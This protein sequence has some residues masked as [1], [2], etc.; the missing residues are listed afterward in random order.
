[1]LC[2]VL[3]DKWIITHDCLYKENIIVLYKGILL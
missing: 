1:M 3:Y 2:F